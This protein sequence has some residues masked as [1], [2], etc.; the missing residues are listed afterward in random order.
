MKKENICVLLQEAIAQQQPVA[1]QRKKLGAPPL[2][3]VPLSLSERLLL[4]AL[5]ADFQPDGYEVVRLRDI[6]EIRGDARTAFHARIMTQEGVLAK[7]TAP[8]VPLIDFGALL[9]ALG[10]QR[11]PVIVE[12]GGKGFLLGTIEKAGKSKLRV[13]YIG[14]DGQV[15]PDTTRIPYEDIASVHFGGRYLNLVARYA[16]IAA[17]VE[18]AKADEAAIPAPAEPPAPKP[19]KAAAPVV[20]KPARKPAAPKTTAKPKPAA[21]K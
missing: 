6:T 17:H 10:E 11:E 5:Y 19:V 14:T 20:K 21:T 2:Y 4:V 1:L 3:C 7:L 13:R 18:T 8:P 16:Q 12:D 9:A 15:D